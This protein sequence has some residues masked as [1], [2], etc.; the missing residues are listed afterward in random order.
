MDTRSQFEYVGGHQ[1]PPRSKY[2]I[3]DLF[4]IHLLFLFF[5]S[6]P[7]LPVSDINVFLHG[8]LYYVS[9]ISSYVTI[10]VE[11]VTLNIGENHITISFLNITSICSAIYNFM[12]KVSTCKT[13][14]QKEILIL[15]SE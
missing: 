4:F 2:D 14:T 1:H 8:R 7:N 5:I 11:F 6:S 12:S 13:M 15:G 9:T 3:W 10:I